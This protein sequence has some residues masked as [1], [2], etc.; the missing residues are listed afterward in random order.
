MAEADIDESIKRKRFGVSLKTFVLTGIGKSWVD[1]RLVK[2]LFAT[3]NNKAHNLGG[4]SC[5]YISAKRLQM[6]RNL[7]L[8]VNTK[9]WIGIQLVNISRFEHVAFRLNPQFG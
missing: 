3:H 6:E 8:R 5:H 4:L 1:F 2:V 9:S 7:V